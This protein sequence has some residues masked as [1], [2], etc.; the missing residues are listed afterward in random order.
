MNMKI[1]RQQIPIHLGRV[2]QEGK[3]SNKVEKE[4]KKTL[5]EIKKGYNSNI[6][7]LKQI[8]AKSIKI[9]HLISKLEVKYMK[10]EHHNQNNIKIQLDRQIRLLKQNILESVKVKDQL[11]QQKGALEECDK[12]YS[13]YIRSDKKN[14][15]SLNKVVHTVKKIAGKL[16]KA[17]N[18]KKV[19]ETAKKIASKL[20]GAL[21]VR[22]VKEVARNL[23]SKEKFEE[24]I[25]SDTAFHVE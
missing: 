19:E 23:M 25:Y 6:Q 16:E 9:E 20:D 4:L 12:K 1:S 14:L 18:L 17:V 2:A 15:S 3:E 10:A 7:R 24:E 21:N 11:V 8:N 13:Q 5:S 22:Q